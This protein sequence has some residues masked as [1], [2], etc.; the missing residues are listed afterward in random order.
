MFGLVENNWQT[1]IDFNWKHFRTAFYCALYFTARTQ[2][3]GLRR[4]QELKADMSSM[5]AS[6]KTDM[7]AHEKLKEEHS[8]STKQLEDEKVCGVC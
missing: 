7:E 5:E 3:E 4:V 1:Y 2:E 8:A 6:M